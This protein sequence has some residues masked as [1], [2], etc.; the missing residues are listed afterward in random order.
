MNRRNYPKAKPASREEVLERVEA[1]CKKVRETR[2]RME[3]VHANLDV[4][5]GVKLLS[6]LL[7]E[8]SVSSA[9]QKKIIFN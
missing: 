1:L 9:E 6:R 8:P 4:E 3:E 2:I 7:N 5:R